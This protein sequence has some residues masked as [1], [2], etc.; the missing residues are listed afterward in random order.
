MQVHG[1]CGI[2][3]GVGVCQRVLLLC[4][5][6]VRGRWNVGGVALEA[7]ACF[8]VSGCGHGVLIPA[9]FV[10]QDTYLLCFVFY[11]KFHFVRDC[12]F[13]FLLFGGAFLILFLGGRIISEFAVKQQIQ[14]F[15]DFGFLLQTHNFSSAR[16]IHCATQSLILTVL[17]FLCPHFFEKTHVYIY[18]IISSGLSFFLAYFLLCTRFSSHF[19][20]EKKALVAISSPHFSTRSQDRQMALKHDP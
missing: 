17:V 15:F 19:F 8:R 16:F 7:F 1:P 18:K 11:S 9:I 5:A 6:L 14:H 3:L 2:F 10:L 20:F 4:I 12:K 13:V